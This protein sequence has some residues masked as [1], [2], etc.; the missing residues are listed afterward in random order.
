MKKLIVIDAG[1]SDIVVALILNFKITKI[2][3]CKTKVFKNIK[4]IKSL[5]YKLFSFLNK[6]T[7][8]NFNVSSIISSVS[9]FNS[10]EFNILNSAGIIRT[11][12]PTA[13][14]FKSARLVAA[15]IPDTAMSPHFFK[16]P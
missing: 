14:D 7:D 15:L 1:N 5:K 3:R 6:R 13:P 9:S 12:T 4:D 8:K 16:Y 11:F 10:I 2:Y